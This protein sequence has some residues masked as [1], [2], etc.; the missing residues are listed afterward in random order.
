MS[1]DCQYM[2]SV[3]F[4]TTGASSH[5]HESTRDYKGNMTLLV[6][7]VGDHGR[8][9]GLQILLVTIVGDHCG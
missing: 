4:L 6:T 1:H 8:K 9:R 7:I 5:S 2:I 3:D